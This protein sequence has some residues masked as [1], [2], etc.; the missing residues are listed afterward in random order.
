M[1][2]VESWYIAYALLGLSAAGLIPILLPLLM[3]RESG[4]ADIGF[5]MAAFS[6]GG[7][8][9]PLWGWLADR[10][11]LHQRLLV[12]GLLGTGLGAIFFP[13]TL[14][15]SCRVGLALLSGVGLATASTV[16]NLFIVEVHPEVEWDARIGWLQ[17]FYGCGQVIG[18]VLAGLIGQS[19]P[20]LGLWLAGGISVAAVLPA[21]LGTRQELAVITLHRPVLAHPAHHAE[22]PVS[23]PQHLYH[24][25]S[26]H[27][28][29]TFFAPFRASFGLF[30][31]AWLL[32]F[33]GSAA[34]FSFYPVLM[35]QVYGVPPGLS[36]AGY[37]LAAGLGLI[38]YAPA[39]KWS[40]RRGS[41]TILRDA[42]VLRIVAFIALTLLAVISFPGRGWLAMMFFLFVVLAWSFL[43][44]SSTALVA[45]LSPENEGEGMGIFS[46]VTALSGVIGAALGGWAANQWGYAVIPI[47][48]I[49]GVGV[50]FIVLIVTRFNSHPVI[51]G[52]KE[53]HQ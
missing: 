36:S 4:A 24:H 9:A 29:R 20:E 39:G 51:Q 10:Y 26:M 2:W 47:M 43:S 22:W 17:T 23:S 33:S 16:A 37:A 34:F 30:L 27:G 14:S 49:I 40:T 46:A 42:L 13:L 8:M 53:V 3:G 31:L 1:K 52:R 32:S 45:G 35:Q 12:G 28:V 41:Q 6:L 11:R 15:L 44:V 25:L 7:L 5:V 38:L 18:L 21:L 19:A 48:G 50:G